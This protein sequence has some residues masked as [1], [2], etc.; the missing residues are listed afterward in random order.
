MTPDPLPE[1]TPHPEPDE[2][3]NWKELLDPTAEPPVESPN[4]FI[5]KRMRE[6]REE[7]TSKPP[8]QS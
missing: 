5:R 3:P 6:V 1:E 4:D 8:E 7:K 2:K